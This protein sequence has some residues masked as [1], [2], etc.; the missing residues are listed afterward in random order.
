MRAARFQL[1]AVALVIIDRQRDDARA[2]FAR[3]ARANHRVEPAR[4]EDDHRFSGNLLHRR[5]I[6]PRCR[7]RKSRTASKK[8]GREAI[9]ARPSSA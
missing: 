5:Q 7:G 4:Q 1:D 2:R 9:A 8:T 6:G 3:E